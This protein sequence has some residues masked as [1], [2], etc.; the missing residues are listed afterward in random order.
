[1]SFHLCLEAEIIHT[2]PF[3]RH[4]PTPQQAPIVSSAAFHPHTNHCKVPLPPFQ[5]NKRDLSLPQRNPSRNT[6]SP[7]ASSPPYNSAFSQP[8]AN[9]PTPRPPRPQHHRISLSTSAPTTRNM[10]PTAS[11]FHTRATGSGLEAIS[12]LYP[13]DTVASH[14]SRVEGRHNQGCELTSW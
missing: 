2:Y 6:S 5:R 14:D 4:P 1:M 3:Q 13:I 11:A 8:T 9:T 7:R 10:P 12:N